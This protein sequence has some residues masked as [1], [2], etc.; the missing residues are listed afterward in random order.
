MSW[1]VVD[2]VGSAFKRTKKSLLEPFDFWKWMKLTLIIFLGAGSPF[3]SNSPGSG[4]S[5]DDPETNAELSSAFDS[6]VN[7]VTSDQYFSLIVTAIILLVVVLILFAYIRNVME[8]VFVDSLVSNNVRLRKYFRSYLGKGFWL[9]MFR[10]LVAVA[11]I[12]LAI[13]MVLP[14][15]LLM[16]GTAGSESWIGFMFS[17]LLLA[18]AIVM[19]AVISGALNSFINLSIPVSMY[20][21]KSISAAFSR[22]LRTFRN[23]WKQ[24][25]LYWIGRAVLR[26]A[27]G[28]AVGIV[29]IIVAV[30]LLVVLGIV[31][32][33]LYYIFE[34][35][36]S[37]P[38]IIIWSMAG[39]IVFL[40]LLFL[41]FI[42]SIV[43]MPGKVFLKYHMLTFMQHW[44][45]EM[46]IPMFD[47]GQKKLE[48]TNEA[49]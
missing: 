15:F 2:A 28:I 47:T 27:V 21:S 34:P 11:V 38:S 33:A 4:G 3:L 19:A 25:V 1:Y 23:D 43:E 31:D 35:V 16:I 46:E 29:A 17:L 40:E 9:F 26:I 14:V 48:N 10:L 18:V 12:F 22:V 32:L 39:I 24:I 8:Y 44:Y 37:D 36:L 20:G 6:F 30:I 45:L 5:F 7:F 13:I 42:I 49:Y 41:I